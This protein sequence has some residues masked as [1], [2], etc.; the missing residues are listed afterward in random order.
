MDIIIS[1]D[2]QTVLRTV[3]G[4]AILVTMSGFGLWAGHMIGNLMPLRA[5]G[6]LI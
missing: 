2:P 4:A 6:P 1:I 5:K 3:I